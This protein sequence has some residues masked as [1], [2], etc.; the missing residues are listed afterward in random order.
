VAAKAKH[1]G[2]WVRAAWQA[3]GIIL[4]AAVVGLLLNQVRAGR[5]P[6]VVNWLPKARLTLESGENIAISLEKAH[7]A[8]LSKGGVF[9]DARSPEDYKRGHIQGARNLPWEA[10]DEYY[11]S[12]MADIG[13][14][15]L[16]IVYCDGDAC[17]LSKDLAVELLFRGY[18][19]VR[20]LVN[21]WSAWVK[22][23]LPAVRGS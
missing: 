7:A 17:A 1:K 21:G 10:V 9:L 2:I 8:F 15:S 5:V 20:V 11:D 16:I 6:L 3:A 4:V 23:R 14:N 12:V 13:E 19:N 22:N 18:G